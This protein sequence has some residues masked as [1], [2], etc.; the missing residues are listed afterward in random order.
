MIPVI[1]KTS[2]L[3]CMTLYDHTGADLLHECSTF[4][5]FNLKFDGTLF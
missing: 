3:N 2:V 4:R 1:N 5:H